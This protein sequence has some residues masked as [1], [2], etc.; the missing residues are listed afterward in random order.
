MTIVAVPPFIWPRP[1]DNVTVGTSIG[2][3]SVATCTADAVNEKVACVFRCPVA[4][5]FTDFAVRTQTVSVTSGPLNFDFRLETVSAGLPSGTLFGTNSNAAVSVANTDDNVWKTGTLTTPPTVAVGDYM[6]IVVKAPAAGTFSFTWGGFSTFTAP[7]MFPVVKADTVPDGTYPTLAANRPSMAIKIGG[8]WYPIQPFAPV[9]SVVLT[10][11]GS[12]SS[13]NEYGLKFIAPFT[14]RVAGLVA[15]VSNVGGQFTLSL[16]PHN[17]GAQTDAD[18]LAQVTC[19]ANSIGSAT[20]DGIAMYLL[21]T[22]ITI[23]KGSTYDI[24]CRADVAGTLIVAASVMWTTAGIGASWAGADCFQGTRTWTA[25]T[26]NSWA[27]QTTTVAHLGLWVDGLDEP[28][29]GVQSRPN[30]GGGMQ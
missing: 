20:N 23:T 9:D 30:L 16:W 8:T 14:M 29:T 3:T 19:S 5:S 25:G 15:F 6:A 28:A 18:A 2:V 24:G 7:T 13:P 27:N 17:N 12:G 11:F 4:G 1:L 21:A 26:T 22:P 10:A